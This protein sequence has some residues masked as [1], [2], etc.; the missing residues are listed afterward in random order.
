MKSALIVVRL[1]CKSVA[2]LC[3]A[4]FL[5][6]P[7][8]AQGE[9]LTFNRRF[10]PLP[11]LIKPEEKPFRDEIC[12]NGKWSFQPVATPDGWQAGKDIPPTLSEPKADSWDST[13]IKIPSPWNMNSLD[14]F[15]ASDSADYRSFPSYPASWEKVEMA[16]LRREFT[17]PENWKGRRLILHFEAVSGDCEVRVNGKVVGR[18]S[19]KFLPFDLDVTDAVHSRGPNELLVGVRAMRFFNQ[20]GRLGYLTY[21]AG[22]WWGELMLGIWQDVYLQALPPT[23]VTDVFVQSVLDANELRVEVELRNDASAPGEVSVEARVVPWLPS[24]ETNVVSAPENRGRFGSDPMI[25]FPPSPPVLIEAGKSNL[26]R[27]T[28][29]V[30]DELK[31]W[32]PAQPNLYGLLVEVKSGDKVLDRSITRFGWRQFG[33]KDQ[34]FTLNG[35]PLR[36]NA[37]LCHFFG[38]A[39][40]TPRHAWAWYKMLKDCNVNTVRLHA[41]PH[42]RFYLDLADEMGILV[43]DETA[44]YGSSANLNLELPVTWERYADHTAR[45]VRRDR[46][47]AS[48]C[49]WSLENET[50]AALKV[51]T[52]DQ[53]VF[54]QVGDNFIPLV[55]SVRRLDP[56]RP[57][58]AADGDSDWGGRFPVA[59]AHYGPGVDHYR[60]HEQV[61]KP[62]GVTESTYLW[63]GTPLQVSEW[64]GGRAYESWQG[65]A[66]GLAFAVWD[67]LVEKQIK[68]FPNISAISVYNVTY[69]GCWPL[70]FGLRDLT[71]PPELS[72]GVHFTSPF[73]EGQPGTQ[74]ERLGPY[75]TMLN[76]GYDPSLPLYQP[77]PVFDAARDAYATNRPAQ[78]SRR[79]F[80][81]P[82]AEINPGPPTPLA[83]TGNVTAVA[84]LGDRSSTLFQTL[85]QAGVPWVAANAVAPVMVVDLESLADASPTAKTQIDETLKAG[86]TVLVWG[87][88]PKTLN[89][90]NALL[91]LPLQ[92]VA[93][94]ASSLLPARG[95]PLADTL[96]PS[97][98]Y[99]SEVSEARD[100][101]QY[102]LQGPL[103]ERGQVILRPTNLNWQTWRNALEQLKNAAATRSEREAKPPGAALVEFG[104]GGGRLVVSSIE[105]VAPTPT[106]Q[107]FFRALLIGLGIHLS[108]PKPVT[109]GLLDTKGRL[110]RALVLGPLQATSLEEA[111]DKDLAGGETTIA[112][113][114]GEKHGD[115]VWRE[116]TANAEGRFNL[117]SP[118]A[119]AGADNQVVYASFWLFSPR[120]D[121]LL[122]VGLEAKVDLIVGCEAGGE[123]W[124]NG[125]LIHEDRG[126][127]PRQPG[128]SEV[129]RVSLRKGWNHFLVKLVNPSNHFMAQIECADP[130]LAA[131][132][133]AEIARPKP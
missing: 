106:H 32:T 77:T 112:P 56:S 131:Q 25:S 107:E 30:H 81:N 57:W 119:D 103:V 99:F 118:S 123:F 65:R 36:M 64:N 48:L 11:G 113:Q 90:A 12:L 61:G 37:E 51:K 8:L 111:F 91:P 44:I 69:H 46:N 115:H 70:P 52:G 47:Y 17:V 39:H 94:S 68:P 85:N 31:K 7:H 128:K 101:I 15:G 100:V 41:F 96:S 6:V 98:C 29:P 74:P 19:D 105:S 79:L 9:L 104:T 120:S 50:L 24:G 43:H 124:L 95:H 129:S 86:G 126:V 2:L 102:V 72:D 121:D 71:R 28:L 49:G 3:S 116:V 54:D 80:E 53:K 18:N 76:P 62:W 45:L 117:D 5:L 40:M 133:R 20:P 93:R 73:V 97:R 16:W 114:V 125:A 75:I 42:P 108:E 21:P 92:A 83:N 22:A 14:S 1:Q 59:T 34:K 26:T 89:A 82:E 122:D 132:L 63:C 67:E 23:R 58:I 110:T 130:G 87:I 60:A 13:P 4:F 27:L 55:E 78:F 127:N 35:E 33:S 109:A 88:N 84:F 10:A 66:E 38:I